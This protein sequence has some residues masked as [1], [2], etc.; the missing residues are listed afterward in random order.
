MSKRTPKTKCVSL[1]QHFD[2]PAGYV[3]GFGR[4]CGYS[5]DADFLDMAAERFTGFARGQRAHAGRIVLAVMLDPGNPRIAPIDAPGVAHLLIQAD[6]QKP[7]E[8]LH[9]KVALLGFRDPDDPGRWVVRLLVSTGNWTRQTLEESLDLVWR[10]DVT[11]EAIEAVDAQTQLA[12][13]DIHAARDLF[14]YLADYFDHR[15]LNASVNDHVGDTAQARR[16]LDGWLNRIAECKRG[17]PRFFDNRKESLLAQLP[18]LIERAGVSAACNYLAMGSGFYE[19][20][21]AGN[22]VPKVLSRIVATLKKARLTAG[23]EID[24]FVNPLGCQAVAKSVAAL[25][26]EGFTV[27][28]A[29]PSPD[30][31]PDGKDRTLHAK[32]LFGANSRKGSNNCTSAWVYLGSGNLTGPGFDAKASLERGN[33]EAGVVFAPDALC[34]YQETGVV[35]AQVVTNLLPMQ[36]ER[37]YEGDAGLIAGGDMP[38][39]PDEWVAAPVAWMEWVAPGEQKEPSNA[40]QPRGRLCLP[41]PLPATFAFEVLDGT[42]HSCVT[43]DGDFI[44]QHERPRQ[45]SVC[46]TGENGTKHE[47]LLPVL[48]EFGRVAATGLSS[49]D[50]DE[51]AWQL[52]QFP[53]TPDDEGADREGTPD[54]PTTVDQPPLPRT[55]PLRGDY[56]IRQMMELVENIAARQTTVV[57]TDWFAW[58]NRLEQTLIR[59]S[60]S[61]GV[62]S[63]ITLKIN[64]L[65]PLHAAPFRPMFAE[66][67]DTDEGKR[68]LAALRHIE[69]TW[70]VGGLNAIRET[71]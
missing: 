13:S 53:S 46:W 59:A 28:P 70:A 56:A 67:D 38:V 21:K 69:K 47:G 68:Y 54:D 52:A 32:F 30:L 60:D 11:S 39:R 45:V 27:R 49:L 36:W 17:K 44:W 51:V 61:P 35:P 22:Q 16:Q 24:V 18:R 9:A 10:I 71:R 66:T 1:L 58:C 5:A 57:K 8:L 23:C 65:S 37:S 12:C 2:P 34:W 62:Q 15:L 48:D 55:A 3:G 63:F 26:A 19:T 42:G 64:P 20:A 25:A 40:S 33:L 14:A 43:A 7:F 4:V 50:L 41:E 29:R 31:F 6:K